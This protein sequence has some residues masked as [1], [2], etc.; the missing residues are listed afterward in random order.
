[1]KGNGANGDDSVTID[2]PYYSELCRSMNPSNNNID[3]PAVAWSIA[4]TYF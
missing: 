4:N 3:I 2:V 1:V